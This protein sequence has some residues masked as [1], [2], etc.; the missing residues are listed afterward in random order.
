MWDPEA[1]RGVILAAGAGEFWL[2][3]G[4]GLAA[5]A[6]LAW[7]ALRWLHRA[8]VI[9]NTPTSRVRSAH[10]GYVELVGQAQPLPG[11]GVVAPLT[12]LPCTWYR[13]TIE[14]RRVV[15]TSRGTR[16]RWETVESGT[17]SAPFLLVDDTGECVID[18][19]GAE[20]TVR[21]KQVWYGNR[22]HP[23]G[24]AGAGGLLMRL[25]TGGSY[26]YTEERMS[27]GDPLYAL[28]WFETVSGVR[29]AEAMKAQVTALLRRWK[30]DQARL[31]EL[32]DADGDGRVDLEEWEAARR[33]AE[34]VVY[35]HQLRR[36]AEAPRHLLRKPALARQPFLL[37]HLPQDSLA[38]RYRWRAGAAAAGFVIAA[39]V[40][41]WAVLVRLGGG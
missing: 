37:S 9:E 41:L 16:T 38:R 11:A 1:W 36:A 40:S 35:S 31:L 32:F 21:E 34:A 28:G 3:T 20:V 6:A 18:P 17:S 23:R 30:Q 8:R 24:G 19:R 14:R 5:A 33:K 13:Y 12:G 29:D 2:W 26:R 4:L 25:A 22:R 10:Q 15:H 39:P 27:A 7:G